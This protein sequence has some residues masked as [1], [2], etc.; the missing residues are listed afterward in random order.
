MR[1]IKKQN[2]PICKI[3]GEHKYIIEDTIEFCIGC[4]EIKDVIPPM[5]QIVGVCEWITVK[6]IIFCPHCGREKPNEVHKISEKN[7]EMANG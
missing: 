1:N 3:T 5:C 6:N 2:T 4:G 7:Q